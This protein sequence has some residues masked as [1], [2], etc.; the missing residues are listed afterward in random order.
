MNGQPPLREILDSLRKGSATIAT[1]DIVRR[2]IDPS[3][4]T[5]LYLGVQSPGGNPGILLRLPRRLV[6]P[7]RLLPDGGGFALRELVIPEDTDNTASL[8][9]FS[10]DRAFDEVFIVFAED[11]VRR[12]LCE[13]ST[14]LALQQ[15]LGRIVLW[16]RFFRPA[17][18]GHLSLDAQAGLFGELLVL[19]D[20]FLEVTEPAKAIGAWLGPSRAPQDFVLGDAAVEVK[21]SRAKA[22]ERVTI[23][24][25]LQLDDRPFGALGLAVLFMSLGGADCLGLNDLI[26]EIESRLVPYPLALGEF[27]DR[28]LLAGWTLAHAPIYADSRFYIREKRY[29]R[30]MTDFPRIVPGDF[31]QGVGSVTYILDLAAAAPFLIQEETVKTWLQS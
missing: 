17:A 9:L 18:P 28:L 6:P 13:P 16:E 29:Y 2:L 4:S 20:L 1:P 24:S 14:D 12:V 5:S 19:R 25:E 22:S 3:A 8:A 15:F 26:R 7:Q 11:V 27:R 21:T 23:T 10:T 31:P 30:I